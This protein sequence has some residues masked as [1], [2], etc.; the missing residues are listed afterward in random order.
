[1]FLE[2]IVILD[3]ILVI[4][5]LLIILV[6]KTDL[7]KVGGGGVEITGYETQNCKQ[8]NIKQLTTNNPAK[9][10]SQSNPAKR[11]ATLFAL[12]RQASKNTKVMPFRHQKH[13]KTQIHSTV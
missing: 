4:V 5:R 3:I 9:K 8:V 13:R 10:I 1:M 12:S 6:S 7:F 2:M 11:F